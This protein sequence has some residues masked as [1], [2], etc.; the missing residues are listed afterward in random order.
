M[1]VV[2]SDTADPSVEAD[3]R[4][5]LSLAEDPQT[6]SARG[7]TQPIEKLER[8]AFYEHVKR[9]AFAIVVTGETRK[10]GNVILKKGV[11]PL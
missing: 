8:F 3:F 11:T 6:V 9:K 1:E 2:K 10:Y 5:A 4:R 7:Y